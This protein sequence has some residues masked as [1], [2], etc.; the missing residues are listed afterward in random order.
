MAERQKQKKGAGT[1]TAVYAMV[2]TEITDRLG[3][4]TEATGIPLRRVV[5]DALNE[6]LKG[7][8]ND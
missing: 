3:K 5:Q 4:Y 6:Y 2:S 1:M 7:K 8:V